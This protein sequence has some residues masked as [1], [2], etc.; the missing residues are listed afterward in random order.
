MPRREVNGSNVVGDFDQRLGDTCAIR[1]Q[2]GESS[3]VE[4]VAQGA[5]V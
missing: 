2:R 5:A 3:D 4:R 1:K